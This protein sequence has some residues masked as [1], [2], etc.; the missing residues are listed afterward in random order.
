[1]KSGARAGFTLLELLLSITLLALI[2]GAIVGG[3]HFGKRAWET[4]KTYEEVDQVEEAARALAEQLAR[5]Y[6]VFVTSP[7][8]LQ[9]IGFVGQPER[10]RFIELSEGEAQWGGLILTEIAGDGAQGDNLA[11]WTRLYRPAEGFSI[12]RTAMRMTPLLRNAANFKLSYFGVIEKDHPPV[13]SDVWVNR[14]ALPLL[15]AVTVGAK[16]SGHIV[17]VSSTVALRQ[18]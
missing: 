14:E 15:V 3:L 12:A 4:G 1:M 7:D 10:C 2:T 17:D 6:S 18:R 8:K 16:R 5:A 9:I 13:W 11:V